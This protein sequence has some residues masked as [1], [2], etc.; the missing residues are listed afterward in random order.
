MPSKANKRKTASELALDTA[1]AEVTAIIVKHLETLS[2]AE[3][4]RRLKA[5]E[6]RV[7]AVGPT[8]RG[9]AL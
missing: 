9:E 7:A 8:G 4:W 1:V 5:A 3:R 2:P 6:R